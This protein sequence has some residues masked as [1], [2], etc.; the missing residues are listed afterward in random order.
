M[1]R[2]ICTV[3]EHVEWNIVRQATQHVRCKF[4]RVDGLGREAGASLVDSGLLARELWQ[5]ARECLRRNDSDGRAHG[6]MSWAALAARR[7]KRLAYVALYSQLQLPRC[8]A[9]GR[10]RL[11][12]PDCADHAPLLDAAFFGELHPALAR[13]AATSYQD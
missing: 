13:P 2:S 4:A 10:A 5:F 9:A 12:G 6:R 7:A 1:L 11:A 8:A 3:N